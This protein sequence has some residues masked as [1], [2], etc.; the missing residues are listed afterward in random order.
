MEAPVPGPDRVITRQGRRPV[1][2]TS[3]EPKGMPKWVI[4]LVV[5]VILG[6]VAAI[7]LTR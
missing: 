6:V 3:P 2:I 4:P 7:L 1:V 5:V